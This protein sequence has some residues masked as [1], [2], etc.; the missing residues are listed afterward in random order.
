MIGNAGTIVEY[1][2]MSQITTAIKKALKEDDTTK[3]RERIVS[4]FTIQH[5]E[6]RLVEIIEGTING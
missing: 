1:D 2:N 5:R 3:P 6:Q 4:N